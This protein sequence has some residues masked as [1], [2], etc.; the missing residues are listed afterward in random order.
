LNVTVFPVSELLKLDPVI[1]TVDSFAPLSG[2]K[3]DITGGGVL[4]TGGGVTGG[5]VPVSFTA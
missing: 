2:L 4:L 3:E 5:G 1:T